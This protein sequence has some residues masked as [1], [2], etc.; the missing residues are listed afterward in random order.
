M[1]NLTTCAELTRSAVLA[2]LVNSIGKAGVVVTKSAAEDALFA[3]GPFVGEVRGL[4]INIDFR[5]WPALDTSNYDAM[6]GQGAA[7]RAILALRA[8]S[9]FLVKNTTRGLAVKDLAMKK[10]DW[11]W[12]TAQHVADLRA[13]GVAFASEYF[14]HSFVALKGDMAEFVDSWGH[15]TTCSNDAPVIRRVASL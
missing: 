9:Q 8:R 11:V 5:H 13:Q 10:F 6:Y 15:P 3:L 14:P 12:F 4:P 1:S 7:S 2:V